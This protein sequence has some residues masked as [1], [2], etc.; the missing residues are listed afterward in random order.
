MKKKK[1]IILVSII[2]FVITIAC[3]VVDFYIRDS[4]SFYPDD[5]KVGDFVVVNSGGKYYWYDD[6]KQCFTGEYTEVSYKAKG[7]VGTEYHSDKRYRVY[8]EIIYDGKSLME[9]SNEVL[10]SY[11]GSNEYGVVTFVM[12]DINVNL[13]G[14]GMELTINQCE[15]VFEEGFEKPILIYTDFA[16]DEI[17]IGYFGE[18]LEEAEANKQ[19]FAVTY[20][21]EE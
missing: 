20:E 16:D 7:V 5:F 18:N 15:L 17:K 21:K 9:E 4:K 10:L 6:E 8:G 13:D 19:R 3:I 1:I 14:S 12:N 2:V 11:W